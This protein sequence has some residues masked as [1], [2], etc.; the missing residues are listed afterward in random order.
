MY[1]I[2]LILTLIFLAGCQQNIVNPENELTFEKEFELKIKA[3]DSLASKEKIK[4]KEFE[5]HF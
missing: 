2:L 1:K 5:I 3:C 4:D